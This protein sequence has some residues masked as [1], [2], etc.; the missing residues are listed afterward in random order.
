[1][2]TNADCTRDTHILPRLG[3]RDLGPQ[4]IGKALSYD[5]THP[6]LKHCT[7]WRPSRLIVSVHR[8]SVGSCVVNHIYRAPAYFLR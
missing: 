5:T 6:V 7:I 2:Y 1:M 4:R 8:S 3:G